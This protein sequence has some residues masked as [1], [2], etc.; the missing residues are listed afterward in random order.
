ME[1]LCILIA[2]PILAVES[3][4]AYSQARVAACWRGYRRV[5][6]APRKWPSHACKAVTSAKN[7]HRGWCNGKVAVIHATVRQRS[8]REV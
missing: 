8:S 3:I 5:H 7:T 2:K 6:R 4:G 1:P